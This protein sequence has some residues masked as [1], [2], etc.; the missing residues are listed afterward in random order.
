MRGGDDGRC[1][2]RRGS[3]GGGDMTV[4]MGLRK[5]LRVEAVD[6]GGCGCCGVREVKM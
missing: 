3:G 4:I 2:G 6:N 5:G 1:G